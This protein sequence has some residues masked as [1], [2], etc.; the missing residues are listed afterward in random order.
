MKTEIVQEL[1]Q[2]TNQYYEKHADTFSAARNRDWQIF[3][4]LVK[5]I[6]SGDIVLDLG[7]GNGRL[8]PLIEQ[9]GAKYLGVDVSS[10][11][12]NKAQKSYPK[13]HFKKG[14]ILSLN[15]K[16]KFNA[17]FSIA[18]LHHIPGKKLRQQTFF[19]LA[20]C[21][22]PEG[23]LLLTNWNLFQYRFL[24][25]RLK[26]N[27]LKLIGINK[28]GLSDILFKGKRFYHGFSKREI[29]SNLKK[30]GFEVIENYYEK[31]GKKSNRL[32]GANLITIAR[33]KV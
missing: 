27:L 6:K 18:A 19:A 21:L 5:H 14:D 9:K 30:A 22:V 8:Y 25:Q 1:I 4:S 2:K 13:A 16:Q 12:L 32:F 20:A 29:A 11:L 7:C 31:N 28:M 26:N 17:I 33:K 15:L 10:N 23:Y 24:R 3:L